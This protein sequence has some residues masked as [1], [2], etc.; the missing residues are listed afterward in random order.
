LFKNILL[1]FT[2]HRATVRCLVVDRDRRS[3]I[4][5][6]ESGTIKTWEVNESQPRVVETGHAKVVTDLAFTPDS[7]ILATTARGRRVK[8]WDPATGRQ[9]TEFQ[10]HG[11]E[12]S[13][14]A[15]APDGRTLAT[16]GGDRLVKLWT[17]NFTRDKGPQSRGTGVPRLIVTARAT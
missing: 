6:D 1:N 17:L 5:G 10:G 9:L 16:G 2:G 3:L 14:L 7:R 4:A 13:C 15:L 11:P 12:T 8:R